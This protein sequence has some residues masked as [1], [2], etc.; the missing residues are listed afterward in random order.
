MEEARSGEAPGTNHAAPQI[1][2]PERRE[3]GTFTASNPFGDALAGTIDAS[4]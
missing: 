4:C 2:R 1:S 3:A